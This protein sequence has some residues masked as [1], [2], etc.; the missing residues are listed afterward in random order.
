[1]ENNDVEK[2]RKSN[3]VIIFIGVVVFCIGL[4]MILKN[5]V[6]YS[7]YGYGMLS[8]QFAGIGQ[9]P[10]GLMLL[11]LL[12]GIIVL[13]ATGKRFLGWL[14]VVVGLLI[15]ILGIL[16][17]IKFRWQATDTFSAIV[18]FGLTAIGIGLI[19]KGMY[20]KVA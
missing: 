11:P 14:L 17:S 5:T 19:L 16:M 15:I 7:G 1:M 9:L 18:M 20:G 2:K 13:L 3:P 6:S 10:E 8:S 4:F 12:A